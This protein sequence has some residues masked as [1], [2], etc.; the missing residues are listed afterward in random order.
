MYMAI[1]LVATI[2]SQV[3]RDFAQ[4]FAKMR[5]ENG[6]PAKRG[7]PAPPRKRYRNVYEAFLPLRTHICTAGLDDVVKIRAP[8]RCI[9]DM[10]AV[11]PQP[12]YL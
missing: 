8:V 7:G 1:R 4:I 9:L 2:G 6:L 11:L 10:P 3:S 5:A 12:T